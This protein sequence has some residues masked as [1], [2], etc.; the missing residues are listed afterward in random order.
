M[1]LPAENSGLWQPLFVLLGGLVMLVSGG[2]LMVGGAIRLAVRQGMSSLLIGL[3]IVAFGT[4]MPELF[5]SLGASLRNHADIMIGN[6]IGSNI[7][8]IGLIL[9]L[10]T[11]LAPLA[12]QFARVRTELYLII[13]AGL[14]LAVVTA[15][16]Y[17]SW[18][19]GLL[20]VATLI[21]YTAASYQAARRRR[22]ESPEKRK[23]DSDSLLNSFPLIAGMVVL[24]LGLMAFGSDFF[25]D[26]A[27]AL[28]RHFHVSELMIGLTLAA[29]GTSLPEMASSLSA[30]RRREG[31]LLLGNVLGS[32]LFNLLMVMGG[33]ALVAPFAFDP[34]T[35]RRDVPVMLGF[36]LVLVPFLRSRHGLTRWHGA[37]L[38]GGYII[39][40]L[41]LA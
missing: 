25:I 31:D 8:N 21:I 36:T 32:N 13:F 14:L 34:I 12:I 24:G 9:G 39:Y 38:M 20:F 29:V 33:T 4:S 40:L 18:W 35:L 27:V 22:K 41:S 17:F 37:V 16:G 7:A 2:E 26:G 1:S 23:M 10:S 28:A 6:V 5:I 3:T 11:I 19:F 15:Y 30:I